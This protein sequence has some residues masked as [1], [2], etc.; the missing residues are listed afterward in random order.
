MQEAQIYQKKLL[1][2]PLMHGVIEFS[3]LRTEL[4]PRALC[5]KMVETSNSVVTQNNITHILPC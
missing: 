4:S 2:C 5:G 3:V 1:T